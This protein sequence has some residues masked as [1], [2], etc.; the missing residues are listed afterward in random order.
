MTETLSDP[1]PSD[2]GSPARLAGQRF[3]QALAWTDLIAV[4]ARVEATLHAAGSLEDLFALEAGLGAG[5]P[6]RPPVCE[7]MWAGEAADIEPCGL[8][9]AAFDDAGRVLLRKSYLV[10]GADHAG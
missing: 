7:L 6:E 3:A 8:R 4:T 2:A 10:G 1:A 9:L 5:F